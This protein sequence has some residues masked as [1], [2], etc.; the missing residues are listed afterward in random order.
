MK[1][2]SPWPCAP[3]SHA[4]KA[5]LKCALSRSCSGVAARDQPNAPAT[6]EPGITYTHAPSVWAEGFFGQGIVIG[7]A[8][9]GIRWTHNALKSHYRG[10]NGELPT[11]ILTGTTASTA[12]AGR[13]GQTPRAL[14]RQWARSPPL[15]LRWVTTAAAIRSAL[16]PAEFIGYQNM[17]LGIGPHATY[18]ECFEWFLAPYPVGGKTSQGDPAKEPDITTNSWACPPIGRLFAGLL[19]ATVEAQRAAGIYDGGCS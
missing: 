19:Q 1:M 16:R 6:V 10:W 18:T 11:I 13:A 17:D 2:R 4:W 3:I 7:G 9:T 14:R 12:V 15:A 8:D 5:I